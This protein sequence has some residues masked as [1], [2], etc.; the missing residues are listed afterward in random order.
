MKA[1]LTFHRIVKKDIHD[2]EDINIKIFSFIL[3]KIGKSCT[4][5]DGN[6]DSSNN[7]SWVLTFDD[8]FS[9]DYKIVLPILNKHEVNA[10]FFIVPSLIGSPNYLS[11]DQVS[12]LSN[13]GMEIGSHSLNHYDMS[14]LSSSKRI[15]ELNDSKKIIEDKISKEVISFSFPFGRNNN[16]AINDVFDCGYDYCFTSKPGLFNNNDKLIPRISLNCKFSNEDIIKMIK[17]CEEN[18]FDVSLA[19]NVKEYSKKIL[20]MDNYW[21]LRSILMDKFSFLKNN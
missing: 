13:N 15:I 5:L 17:R 8:G 14:T 3:N 6:Q 12:I 10:L 2:Y 21:R 18:R 4:L 7:L 19:Y 1:A 9:S 20:G 16:D 11:W